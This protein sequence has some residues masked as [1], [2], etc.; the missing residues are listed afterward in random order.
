MRRRSASLDEYLGSR[1]AAWTIEGLLP[2]PRLDPIRDDP[3]FLAVVEKHRR[4]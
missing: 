1:G 2:D 3:R 4:R